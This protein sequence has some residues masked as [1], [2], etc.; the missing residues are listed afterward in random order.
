MDCTIH[1]SNGKPRIFIRERSGLR[2]PTLKM[3]WGSD[4]LCSY[5][6][7]IYGSYHVL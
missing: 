1:M 3:L 5:Y 2:P 7:A 6:Q 4:F